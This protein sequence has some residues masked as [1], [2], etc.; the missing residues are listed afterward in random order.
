VRVYP[1]A[2]RYRPR[3]KARAWVLTIARY[4]AL[5]AV[6]RRARELVSGMADHSAAAPADEPD[7][8]RLDMSTP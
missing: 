4:L 8:I 1:A 5:D 3:S 7:G 2:P 6:R